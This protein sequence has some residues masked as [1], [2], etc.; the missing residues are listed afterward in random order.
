MTSATWRFEGGAVGALT[1]TVVQHE[2]NF[3]TTF[4]V[5]LLPCLQGFQDWT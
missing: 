1:H 2:Q 4:E 3:F 5:G